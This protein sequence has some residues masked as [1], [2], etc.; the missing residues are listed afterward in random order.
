MKKIITYCLSFLMAFAS[1]GLINPVQVQAATPTDSYQYIGKVATIEKS[2]DNKIDITTDNKE[3]I[4]LTFLS[5]NIFRLNMELSTGEFLDDPVPN[6]TSHTTKMLEKYENEYSGPTN[7]VISDNATEHIIATPD[8]ELI[9]NKENS[10]MKLVNKKTGAIVWEEKEPLQYKKNRTVQTL[11]TDENENFFGGGMQ[12]GY[13]SHKGTTINIIKNP[14]KWGDGYAASPTPLYISTKGYGVMRHTW[15]PGTYDFGDTSKDAVK[16]LHEENRF[17]AFYF[18]EP[19][20]TVP[21][22]IND[23]VEMTGNPYLMPEYAWYLGHLNCYSRD[24]WRKTN[25]GAPLYEINGENW[26][27]DKTGDVMET[28]N[29]K[30]GPTA[31][32]VLNMYFEKDMPVGLMLPNDGYGCGYGRTGSVE[33]N[34]ENLGKFS[35]YANANGVETGLWT[36]SYLTPQ[37]SANERPDLQRDLANETAKGGVRALKTDVAWVGPGYSMALHAV[38]TAS[39]M[40][41][42]NSNYRSHIISLDG[43]SGTQRYASLWSGD[44]TGGSWEY[45][46]FHIPTYIGSGLSGQPN[47][48]SDQNGIWGANPL[49][50]TRDYQWKAFTP[51]Q[52]DMDGWATEVKMPSYH[53]QY[54]EINRFYLKLKA[55]MLPYNYSNGWE[56]TK[57]GMPMLRAML[58]EYPEDPYTYGKGTQYQYMWGENLLV[59]P[60]YQNVAADAQGNDVRNGI[61]LPDENQVWIDYLSGKQYTGGSIVNGYE[62]PVWKQPVFVKNGAIIPM[63]PENNNPQ[64]IAKDATRIFDVYPSGKTDFTLYEDDGTSTEYKNGANATT[65]ITSEAPVTGEGVA[66]ITVDTPKGNYAS[67]KKANNRATEFIVNVQKEPTDLTLKVGGNK[68]ELTKV[69]SMEDFEAATTAVVYYNENPNLN[70][71]SHLGTGFAEFGEVNT[72]PK[73]YVKTAKNVDITS[74]KVQLVVDGFDNTAELEDDGATTLPSKPENVRAIDEKTDDKQIA[75]AWDASAQATS[76][77]LTIDGK[78]PIIT[79]ISDAEYVL[80]ELEQDTEHTIQ[81]RARNSKG[82]SEWSDIVTYKTKL[83]RYRNVPKNMS[84]RFDGETEPAIYT[85]VLDN[86]IDNNNVTEYSSKDGGAWLGKAFEIDMNSVYHIEKLEYLFRSD[87]GNGAV[88]KFELKYSIDG[89]DWETMEWNTDATGAPII[90]PDV[91]GPYKEAILTFDTPIDAKYLNFTVKDSS[92]GFFQAYEIRPYMV[93]GTKGYLPGDWNE[94]GEIDEGDLEFLKNYSGRTVG[95]ADWDYAGKADMNKNGVIDS[96]DVV[97]VSSKLGKPFVRTGETS[98]GVISLVPNKTNAQAGDEILYTVYGT[99]FND[100]N[101]FYLQTI[102]DSNYSFVGESIQPTSTDIHMVNFSKLAE[103]SNRVNIIFANKGEQPKIKGNHKLAT[104]KLKANND[105]ADTNLTIDKAFI[106]GTDMKEKNANTIDNTEN[107]TTDAGNIVLKEADI[108]SITF[109]NSVKKGM[110]GSTLWQQGNW[111]SLLFNGDKSGVLAEF[112]WV[113]GGKLPEEVLLPTDM[114]FT[115]KEKQG[116]QKVKVYNRVTGTNGRITSIKATAYDGDVAYELGSFDAYQEEYEFDA[117]EGMRKI[118]KVVITP[119]TSTGTAA[120]TEGPT[121][122]RMLSIREIEFISNNYIPAKEIKFKENDVTINVGVLKP[123]DIVYTPTDASKAGLDVVSSDPSVALVQ[124]LID[125][126]GNASYAVLGL[127]AGSATITLTSLS[128]PTVTSTTTITVKD[129]KDTKSLVALLEEVEVLPGDLYSENSYKTLKTR[130]DEAKAVLANGSSTQEDIDKAEINI[131]KAKMN[132]EIRDT[133]PAEKIPAKVGEEEIVKATAPFYADK[134][135]PEHVIDG[136]SGTFWETPYSGTNASLPKDITLTLEDIAEVDQLDFTPNSRLNGAVTEFKVYTSVDGTTWDEAAHEVIAPKT[137]TADKDYST[138]EVKF[139]SREAKYIKFEVLS[140]LESN[141]ATGAKYADVQELAVYGRFAAKEIT[142]STTKTELLIDETTTITTVVK[143]VYTT[144]KDATFTSSDD[145]IASVDANGKVTAHKK[146]MATITVTSKATPSVS[147]TIEIEVNPIRDLSSAIERASEYT[148]ESIY[149]PS[150]WSTFTTALDAAKALL[151]EYAGTTRALVTQDMITTAT[152]NLVQAI[153]G[154]VELTTKDILDTKIAEIEEAMNLLT[155]AEFTKGSWEALEAAITKAKAATT[156]EEIANA[157]SDLT[158]K[159]DNLVNISELKTALSGVSTPDTKYSKASIVAHNNAISQA[160]AV[161]DNPNATM[162]EV[163]GAIAKVTSAKELLVDVSDLVVAIT[164]AQKQYDDN[165]S[166]YT[167]AYATKL[168]EAIAVATAAKDTVLTSTDLTNAIAALKEVSEKAV[169]LGDKTDLTEVVDSSDV[170]AIIKNKNDYTQA[171]YAK[172][173]LAL[174]NAKTVLANPDAT[175]QEI[176]EA[177]QLLQKYISELVKAPVIEEPNKNTVVPPKN[178]S[179]IKTAD[180]T[181]MSLLVMMAGMSLIV[182][183][184]TYRKKKLKK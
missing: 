111:K 88:K 44:Q 94:N 92:G 132:L 123:L 70:K 34:I 91:G 159:F 167:S 57:T 114:N 48:G 76:Y 25:T 41:E 126:N 45:I 174:E 26:L 172:F 80:K 146:G 43:W 137:Y 142:A 21:T 129:E 106:V 50:S 171:S 116:I 122:N 32:N 98:S 161:L 69:N 64:E 11:K 99:D 173:E 17:D 66:T 97:F 152:T 119:L 35:N 101:A 81:V 83:D 20:N 115:F 124:K 3:K 58:L 143:P 153:D 47:V 87:V 154:L 96:Y 90:T 31:E 74:N 60:V 102:F 73:V 140:A 131:I 78:A 13:F 183:T 184:F 71:Y 166:K 164:N 113:S 121:T 23:F 169:Y 75:F 175:Q 6:G 19:D 72:T 39:K 8:I 95:D 49:I 149:T 118:D 156:D 82:T 29:G 177:L 163:T 28:L 104:F 36:Q 134:N 30:V 18:V 56:A 79:G 10:L 155:K 151:E 112:K 84:I 51:I 5:N 46:R 33:S 68:V 27:Q 53:K 144:I 61:Y 128:D 165:I 181:N 108:K 147:T 105:I 148:D 170:E 63:T 117:P 107:I 65:K 86:I 133:R 110:D 136:D 127:K 176:N 162:A 4:R 22:V 52:L 141:G 62:V 14:N 109:D 103:G 24:T 37:E 130:I 89:I 77:D 178:G 158:T 182:L 2:A 55:E 9:I 93:E 85:G 12:N 1:F 150:S 179:S 138:V 180:A 38:A 168:K 145:T 139:G 100:V 54:A 15:Q 160:Q 40:I 59:A 135:Y 157:M 67:T 16:A 120:V 42:D 125:S 7:L